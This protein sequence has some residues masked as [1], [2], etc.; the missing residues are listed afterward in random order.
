[1]TSAIAPINH[2]KT[3]LPSERILTDE[4]SLRHYGRDW[5]TDFAPSPAAIVL[6]ETTEEVQ[7]VIGYCASARI[8]VVPSG[9]RTGLSGGAT[10]TQGEVV[11]SLERMN[12]IFSLNRVERTVHCQ[13]GA[14][15]E[16][17]QL[18]AAEEGLYF[19][20]DFASKGSS[21]IGGNIATNAGGIRVIRYGMLRE[22]VLGLT[23]VTGTG[24]IIRLNGSLIKNQSGFDL[25][26]LLIG[27]EGCLAV[28]TEAIL[29]LTNPPGH[30]L[31]LLCGLSEETRILSLLE[32]VRDRFPLVSVFEYFDSLA[33]A[34]VMQH[35]SLPRPLSADFKGYALIEIEGDLE[36]LP[37]R[38]EELLSDAAERGL[39]EDAVISQNSRQAQDLLRYRESISETLSS[40][41][42]LHKNDIS[43]PPSAIPAFLTDF[44]AALQKNYPDFQA[45][46]FGHIGDG[47]LHINILK[48]ADITD[49]QFFERCHEAD[50][51]LFEVVRTHAGSIS[52][53]HGVGLLKRD[54]L[55]FT[56]SAEEISL[57]RGI[58]SVFDP[59]GILN[60]GK[61]LLPAGQ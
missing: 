54:F 11:L 61:V 21:Q 4:H 27:S 40:L 50:R 45:V 60:P 41:H 12:Q 36:T 57:M 59:Q 38:A 17:I 53:E 15:T 26:Q 25:R 18:R 23:A 16:K 56:R 49:A 42:T 51:I 43:V 46:I 22:W 7:A 29:G 47:N 44:K 55:H 32:L 2:L 34:K 28:I 3:L 35:Q 20:I 31:R 8:A 14:V 33:L 58:K 9:G 13:A 30:S 52:A 5:L 19:P 37:Q 1:M 6:P 24:D 10:A 39:I 48:P